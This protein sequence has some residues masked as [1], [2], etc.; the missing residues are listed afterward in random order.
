MIIMTTTQIGIN[1]KNKTD[2]QILSYL[3]TT[4][5]I[6]GYIY[7]KNTKVC[8]NSILGLWTLAG[9]IPHVIEI[10]PNKKSNIAGFTKALKENNI[11]IVPAE[12]V[13][14]GVDS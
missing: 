2:R 8:I 11:E 9:D 12:S 14:V 10:C 4:Y 3:A 7:S 6:N 1:F 5:S 13:S